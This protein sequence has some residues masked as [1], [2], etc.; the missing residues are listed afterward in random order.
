MQLTGSFDPLYAEAFI[1]V[2]KYDL[3]FEI[4]MVNN[5]KYNLLNIQMEF[6]SNVEV[7]VLEK[8]QSVNLRPFES[9]MLRTQL[10]FAAAEFGVIFGYINY[11]N[12]AGLE[13]PY[14]IT[15][16]I[17]IDY[18]QYIEPAVISETNFKIEW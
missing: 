10:R 11:D 16:E 18:M 9:V 6:S 14:L 1:N 12:H 13:Q 2:N 5:T 8:A 17:K 15:E 4:L 7:L 3:F